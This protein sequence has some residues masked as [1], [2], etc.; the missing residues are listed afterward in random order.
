[1]N[2]VVV[3]PKS[4]GDIR[5]FIDMQ[6]ANEGVRRNRHPIPNVDEIT[7]SISGSKVFSKLDL[8]WGYHQLKLSSESQEITMFATHC[9]LFRYKRLLF[10]VNSASE[11]YQYEIQTALAG[12]EGQ[13]SI[14]DDIIV[15]CKHQEEHDLQLEK[16]IVRL[17]ERGVTIN[18]EKCQF[19]MD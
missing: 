2:P 16:V 1:M 5:L 3:V 17:K 11:K 19:I 14:S 12:I 15:H 9:A 7:Q 18:A 6:M 8:K 13:E 4:G 10:G